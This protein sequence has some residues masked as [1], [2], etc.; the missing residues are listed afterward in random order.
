[1]TAI[2]KF[3]KPFTQQEPIPAADIVD[4]PRHRRQRVCVGQDLVPRHHAACPQR[5]LDGVAAGGAGNTVINTL[6]FGIFALK[7][8]G[9]VAVAFG[10]IIA[11]Q[12]AALHDFDG[13]FDRGGGYRFLLGEGLCKI[14]TGCHLVP[15]AACCAQSAREHITGDKRDTMQKAAVCIRSLQQPFW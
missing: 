11:M 10:Q 5:Q 3:T 7:L 1:M 15:L 14:C 4:R 6:P 9:L 13:A 2:T 8:A 12:A